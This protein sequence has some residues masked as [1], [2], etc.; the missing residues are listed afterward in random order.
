[1][2]TTVPV[3]PHLRY[4]L[5]GPPLVVSEAP[6]DVRRTGALYRD[7]L[8]GRFA[9]YARHTN[10]SSRTLRIGVALTNPGPFTVVVSGLTLSATTAGTRFR[11]AMHP[12]RL[13][14]LPRTHSVWAVP[15][16]PSR[17][18]TLLGH[19]QVRFPASGVYALLD[20]I[21]VPAPIIAT[22]YAAS[23]QPHRPSRLVLLPAGH[24]GL[25][26]TFPHAYALPR[27]AAYLP[28]LPFP[29]LWRSLASPWPAGTDMVDGRTVLDRRLTG[30]SEPP[31]LARSGPRR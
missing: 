13:V 15:V 20:A 26:A 29:S 24:G 31:P 23:N 30:V 27:G 9:L 5:S 7:T 22:V 16:A 19:A 17:S 4:T 10:D 8:L 18:L 14:L 11:A 21:G 12:E 25:R 2:F 6:L 28:P 3:S 1:M